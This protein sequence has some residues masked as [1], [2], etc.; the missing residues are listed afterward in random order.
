MVGF[1]T[2]YP[3]ISELKTK[4]IRKSVNIQNLHFQDYKGVLCAI[5][6][7]FSDSTSTGMLQ[8][9]KKLKGASEKRTI[10]IDN[11]DIK[12][13]EMKIDDEMFTGIRFLDSKSDMIFEHTWSEKGEWISK[14]VPQHHQIIG[15]QVKKAVGSEECSIQSLAFLTWKYPKLLSLEEIP[16][17]SLI[18]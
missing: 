13:I 2:K 9:Q 16:D 3:R 18:R 14:S 6:L 10:M 7:D 1:F 12:T 4:Q 15:L 11:R 5:G 17:E 8:S